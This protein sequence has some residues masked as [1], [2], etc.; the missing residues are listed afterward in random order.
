MRSRTQGYT[1]HVL[2][3][4]GLVILVLWGL[5]PG[6]RAPGR[7]APP[8]GG[9]DTT[10]RNVKSNRNLH[11]A[12]TLVR[13]SSMAELRRRAE[14]VDATAVS[15][16]LASHYGQVV[17]LTGVLHLRPGWGGLPDDPTL[18]GGSAPWVLTVDRGPEVTLV[19]CG[20]ESVSGEGRRVSVYGYPAGVAQPDAPVGAA[21]Q[22]VLVGRSEPL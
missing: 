8:G 17:K 5:L 3:L 21:P 20:A 15:D 18:Y 11:R 14:A 12:L 6:D 16:T 9:W 13:G 2:V 19:L 10:D 1:S 22:L 7:V 4:A